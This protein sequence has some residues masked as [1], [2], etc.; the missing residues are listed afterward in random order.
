M[1]SLSECLKLLTGT[2]KQAQ[3]THCQG[4]S[5][6]IERKGIGDGS[7]WKGRLLFACISLGISKKSVEKKLVSCTLQHISPITTPSHQDTMQTII[8]LKK[9]DKYKSHSSF[10]INLRKKDIIL[11]L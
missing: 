10:G 11:N 2:E 4:R 8:S 6:V 9:N 5:L 3:F 1:L 7:G